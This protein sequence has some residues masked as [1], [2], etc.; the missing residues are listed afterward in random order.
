MRAHP[1]VE[2]ATA[3][4]DAPRMP[5]GGSRRAWLATAALLGLWLGLTV[6]ARSIAPVLRSGVRQAEYALG[7]DVC[8]EPVAPAAKESK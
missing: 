4:S 7:L 3:V 1:S 2:Q 6:G 8:P 5:V